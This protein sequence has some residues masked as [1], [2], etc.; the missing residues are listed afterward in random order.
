MLNKIKTALKI[1][2][3]I[4]YSA[5]LVIISYFLFSPDDPEI[6]KGPIKSNQIKYDNLTTEETKIKLKC[7]GESDPTLDISGKGANYTLTAGLC[8]RKWSRNITILSPKNFIFGGIAVDN[9]FSTGLWADYQRFMFSNFSLGGGFAVF[10]KNFQ[11]HTG[12]GYKW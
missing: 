3:F 5:A 4:V 10:R 12:I 1:F 2:A 8:D 6:I 11:I 7:Y 9:Q